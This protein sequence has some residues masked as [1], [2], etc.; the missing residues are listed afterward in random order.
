MQRKVI[1]EPS[2]DEIHIDSMYDDCILAAYAEGDGHVMVLTT[3]DDEYR[4][5]WLYTDQMQNFNYSGKDLREIVK[6]M[7]EDS[8]EVFQFDDE[9]DFANWLVEIFGPDN[10][11]KVANEK[12]QVGLKGPFTEA[13][14]ESYNS[15]P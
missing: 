15:R 10:G 9:I 3:I 13:Q 7:I 6:E 4:S 5:V 12:P 11:P 8:L 1:L 2:D 14:V